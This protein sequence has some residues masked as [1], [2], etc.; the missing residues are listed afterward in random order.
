MRRCFQVN[1]DN[2]KNET[3]GRNKRG[4]GR[5]GRGGAIEGSSRRILSHVLLLLPVDDS[6]AIHPRANDNI[7]CG[8]SSVSRP[9]TKCFRFIIHPYIRRYPRRNTVHA[10]PR[11]SDIERVRMRGV[12]SDR[13]IRGKGRGGQSRCLRI[14]I[15]FANSINSRGEVW[16]SG[17]NLA[18]ARVTRGA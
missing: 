17:N 2:G 3:S 16:R 14:L 6:R 1:R 10:I 8:S 7:K 9:A 4:R 18:A 15:E 12:V 5:E 13:R 11:I